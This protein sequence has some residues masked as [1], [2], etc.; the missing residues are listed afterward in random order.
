MNTPRVEQLERRRRELLRE[1]LYW[2]L[3]SQDDIVQ[4]LE[5]P[6]T[7]NFG[8][9]Y[10]GNELDQFEAKYMKDSDGTLSAM[11]EIGQNNWKTST[12][13]AEETASTPPA[14]VQ[15]VG[16]SEQMD[17]DRSD[18]EI[19]QATDEIADTADIVHPDEIVFL[20]QLDTVPVA[21]VVSKCAVQDADMLENNALIYNSQE[22]VED[23][24]SRS[25]NMYSFLLYSQEQPLYDV[26]SNSN[27]LVSTR[28]WET[29]RDELVRVR[30]MKRIEELKEKGKWS[31]WQPQKHRAPPRSKAHW[32]HVL[33]EMT[34]MHADFSEER[35]VRM[36]MARAVSSWVMDYHQ[37]VD[38][39]RYTVAG[40]R[41]ILPDDFINGATGDSK[42]I[43]PIV[44]DA[45]LNS[46]SEPSDLDSQSSEAGE[47][48]GAAIE[49]QTD[50]DDVI[51]EGNTASSDAT[52]VQLLA[53]NSE[54]AVA[55]ETVTDNDPDAGAQTDPSLELTAK[56]EPSTL[57][58]PPEERRETPIQDTGGDTGS[59]TAM[60]ESV[61]NRVTS[62]APAE[63]HVVP[64]STDQYESAISVYHL[65]AQLP[66]I[67]GLEE[68]LGD[69]IYALQ[70]LSGL[71]P[72]CPAWE[73]MY[74]DILDVSPVVP[75]C[76]TMWPDFEVE[77]AGSEEN[78]HA[79]LGD[80]D[81]SID[82][83]SLLR[84]SADESG[85]TPVGEPE[86]AGARSIFTRNLLAPP[87]LP[88]FTQ[89]N[90]AQRNTHGSG[91]QPPADTAI[92]QAIS[93]ACPGQAVFEWSAER[94]KTLAKIVQQ[95]TGNWRLISESLN[96]ALALYGSR[97]LTPRVCYER[98]ISIKED[99]PLDRTTVQTGFDE[100][101]FGRRKQHS[102]AR[103]LAVQPTV[104]P[105][106]A[107]QLATSIVSH[108]EAL[109]VVS[110]SKK[111]RDSAQTPAPIPPR[112]IK[113]LSG[114]QKALTPAELS[115]MKFDN[116]RRLQQIFIEQRQATAAAAALAMQQQRALNPQ[117]QALQISRQINMLQTM[118]ANGRG[119]QR[120]LTPIQIRTI[121][122]Q[123][124]NLQQIQ[125]Q[126]H[127]QAQAHPQADGTPPR[128]NQP[129]Q[130]QQQSPQPQLMHSSP[131]PQQQTPQLFHQQQQ[132][133]QVP[134]QFAQATQSQTQSAVGLPQQAT[135]A[136]QPPN[137]N[138]NLMQGVQGAPG[139]R[140][141]PEQMQ[142]ILQARAG[143]GRPPNLPPALAAMINA[144]AQQTGPNG[145]ARPPN[146]MVRPT[147]PMAM[148]AMLPPQQRHMF[149]QHLA[150]QQNGMGAAGQLQR[151]AASGMPIMAQQQQQQSLAP[152]AT[153]GS[154]TPNVAASP[155]PGDASVPH[156]MSP[157]GMAGTPLLQSQ[158]GTSTGMNV[159]QAQA[160]AILAMQLK[161]QQAQP[162]QPTQAMNQ[163]QLAQF[164]S[165][166]FPHQ[167]AQVSNQQRMNMLMMRQQQ[168]QQQQFGQ[169]LPGA[170]GIPQS[171]MALNGLSAS[172]Q[173]QLMTQLAQN[174]KSQPQVNLSQGAPQP[175]PHAQQQS[176]PSALQLMRMRQALQQQNAFSQ[177]G[178]SPMALSQATP[179]VST[180]HA[181]S[182]GLQAGSQ[183]QGLMLSPQMG[184]QP[185]S[186]PNS[187]PQ[188]QQQ[189]QRPPQVTTPQRPPV[190]SVTG[191]QT[192]Q[193]AMMMAA[194][195]AAGLSTST[196]QA[197]IAQIAANAEANAQ[198]TPPAA[199]ASPQL[200]EGATQHAAAGSLVAVQAASVGVTGT[201]SA[202][203][204]GTATSLPA[205][206]AGQH[207]PGAQHPR[208]IRP[209]RPGAVR[210][211][212]SRPATPSSA[213]QAR[214]MPAGMA[215]TG[216]PRPSM[217]PRPPAAGYTPQRRPPQVGHSS[218][219][220]GRAAA[221]DGTASASAST[222]DS[223]PGT[224][225][226]TP[227]TSV[228]GAGT[229]QPHS[230][231][232]DTAT[233][234]QSPT[235][236][237]ARNT[238]SSEQA[239][240]SKTL[241]PGA[242]PDSM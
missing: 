205:V 61:P 133:Q 37:A 42:E 112:E 201:S 155:I 46:D 6:S 138:N 172:Q 183:P 163:P 43:L 233:T 141:T 218:F 78:T 36:A 240:P 142:Q 119:L 21:D 143:N 147:N 20:S 211:P 77:E 135:L 45:T 182:L 44:E 26:I 67:D 47:P 190:S 151:A 221:Q 228:L 30:V 136:G 137:N 41:R 95:Y 55:T 179:G 7:D 238:G 241:S 89:A 194:A 99:Y 234:R 38:K 118:L 199:Q 148:A 169:G 87:L 94:D 178:S 22:L 166:L 91:G 107:M 113:S 72:Y 48:E 122:Q 168:Q 109:R 145:M 187:Q 63:D 56:D 34:W 110:E 19:E 225:G 57:A 84:L 126:Q 98:W 158:A 130:Q 50:N 52:T 231:T 176:S 208:T 181:F 103:Q 189:P 4:L 210:P 174:M 196:A 90:K 40:R 82:I 150:Q 97:S 200:A 96:H 164:L 207:S 212:T 242:G 53:S 144:R 81:D 60:A 104:A 161:Q 224:R 170:Q 73:E 23:L 31:F 235:Q 18:D 156:Q 214:A 202:A 1:Y 217:A 149:L 39:S 140:F 83:Q 74:C 16:E 100:Q 159:A 152:V 154:T 132:Q 146:N 206:A 129:I 80:T 62:G 106:P 191:M 75:I 115:K 71:A 184:A 198:Q 88:M 192:P 3:A 35:K 203:I 180:A 157:G 66:G 108:S 33:T 171:G 128:I 220:A 195:T 101:E 54:A 219:V 2:S 14:A 76:K 105:Q 111:K 121:Q 102:W 64:A 9:A 229:A 5:R 124:H 79:V 125:Q 8:G 173:Q 70:S 197:L 186:Q 216:S 188:P 134:M 68:I 117:L 236:V 226:S 116:D 239:S 123:L 131:P 223:T 27:K 12:F 93:E 24:N 209:V 177:A 165:G 58:E 215:G 120:P 17:I 127:A 213:M 65:L 162:T 227:N 204:R 92:Q 232:H 230:V 59:D 193:Q 167:L 85:R 114:E 51:A 237:E 222:L 160:Q 29:V 11:R 185:N 153:A 69:S 32:D 15:S 49:T 25:V 139:V 13:D 86:L 28:D 175:T 10:S